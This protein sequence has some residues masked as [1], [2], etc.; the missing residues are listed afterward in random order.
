[1]EVFEWEVVVE[2]GMVDASYYRR[3]NLDRSCSWEAFGYKPLLGRL[4]PVMDDHYILHSVD[5]AG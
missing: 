1:V 5:L 3:T 4:G 2:G